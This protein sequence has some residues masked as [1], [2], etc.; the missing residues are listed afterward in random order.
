MVG[1]Q[2]GISMYLD[3]AMMPRVNC[4]ICSTQPYGGWLPGSPFW[5][6]SPCRCRDDSTLQLQIELIQHD[7]VSIELV[8][9]RRQEWQS[10]NICM[11]VAMIFQPFQIAQLLQRQMGMG[12]SLEQVTA[13]G[14]QQ[15]GAWQ[16]RGAAWPT[17]SGGYQRADRLPG[18]GRAATVR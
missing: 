9:P 10:R 2:C 14:V 17:L 13:P 18:F 5:E 8:N 1:G 7:T 12:R 16:W 15:V 11:G 6:W 3:H 4:S